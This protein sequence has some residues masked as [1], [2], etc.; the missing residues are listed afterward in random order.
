MTRW[1]CDS[2][3]G[4][5]WIFNYWIHLDLEVTDILGKGRGKRR[6]GVILFSSVYLIDKGDHCEWHCSGMTWSAVMGTATL[7]LQRLWSQK[8][9][10]ESHIRADVYKLSSPSKIQHPMYTSK[11]KLLTPTRVLGKNKRLL[12][13]RMV[14]W[15]SLDNKARIIEWQLATLSPSL[16]L[17]P[18]CWLDKKV[19]VR[20]GKMTSSARGKVWCLVFRYLA[21]LI[22]FITFYFLT[23]LRYLLI[24]HPY[25]G[26]NEKFI[27][28]LQF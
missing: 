15:D 1:H 10:Y 24:V 27:C 17:Q 11:G 19:L 16:C 12:G 4:G 26:V 2:S 13:Y 9:L 3:F 21:E 28:S 7:C 22:C 18:M 6:I 8:T 20:A 23:P 14:L 5:Q 25:A